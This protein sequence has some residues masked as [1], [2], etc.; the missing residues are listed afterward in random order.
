MK[1]SIDTTKHELVPKHFLLKEEDAKKI[2]SK[3]NISFSQLPRI[4]RKDPAILNFG[5]QPKDVIK[6]ERNSATAGKSVYYRVV[7][8]E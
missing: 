5:A 4:S 1:D 6:I 3:Y 8:D 7:V 2:L